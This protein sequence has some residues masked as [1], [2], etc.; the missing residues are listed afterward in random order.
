MWWTSKQKCWI[1]NLYSSTIKLNYFRIIYVRTG[2]ISWRRTNDGGEQSDHTDG[3]DKAGPAVPVLCG[4]DEG[5]QNLP[6]DGEEVHDVVE[7]RW[8]LLLPALVIVVILT[9][10][11]EK[12][13]LKMSVTRFDSL[14]VLTCK[15]T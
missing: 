10:Q 3:D 4:R 11:E 5:K 14:V 2:S 12:G 7:T 13:K 8:Q 9:C 6:E 15:D 1:F